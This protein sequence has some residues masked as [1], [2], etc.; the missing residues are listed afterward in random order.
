MEARRTG[1]MA[2]F[3]T[4]QLNI[5]TYARGEQNVRMRTLE[6]A[7]TLPRGAT[8]LARLHASSANAP[9]NVHK[10]KLEKVGTEKSALRPSY[11]S[12]GNPFYPN[13]HSK[14]TACHGTSLQTPARSK[15][16]SKLRKL[17]PPKKRTIQTS[18]PDPAR[19]R[20]PVLPKSRLWSDLVV[21]LCVFALVHNFSVV[22]GAKKCR[23]IRSGE[24]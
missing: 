9:H 2:P 11:S 1:A 14:L 7:S 16:G 4:S 15:Q 18:D 17:R 10:L 24:C 13:Y 6:I 21:L 8:L 12:F 20:A 23:Q 22:R 19:R 5:L 3:Q